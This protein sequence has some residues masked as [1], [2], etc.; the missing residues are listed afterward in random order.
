MI[1]ADLTLLSCRVAFSKRASLE[2]QVQN[3]YDEHYVSC[4]RFLV[5]TGS[6]ADDALELLQEAF[7]RLCESVR[8]ERGWTIRGTGCFGSA[9]ASGG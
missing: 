4:Y 3:L 5:M 2:E 8:S 7:L 6:S 1:P 9:A